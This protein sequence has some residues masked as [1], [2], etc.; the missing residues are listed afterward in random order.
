MDFTDQLDATMPLPNHVTSHLRSLQLAPAA[1]H[2]NLKRPRLYEE[3]LDRNEGQLAAGG[4]LVTRTAPYTGRSPKDRFIVRDAS[5]AD[6]INWG[7]VKP[8]HVRSSSRAD[9][10][11]RRGTRPFRAGPPRRLG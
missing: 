10:R 2:Y 3:A 9:G 8:G 7:E 1:V 4:P 5:V 6:Q 11:A